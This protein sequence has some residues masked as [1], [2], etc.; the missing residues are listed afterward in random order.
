MEYQQVPYSWM[1]S[2]QPNY[3]NALMNPRKEGEFVTEQ[4]CACPTSQLYAIKFNKVKCKLMNETNQSCELLWF[5]L[6]CILFTILLV[7]FIG[8]AAT[9]DDSAI[10]VGIIVSVAAI[11]VLILYAVFSE[12]THTALEV[13]YKCRSCGHEV[14]VTYEVLPQ[15]F[16]GCAGGDIFNESG[17][18]T[19]TCQEPEPLTL[20]ATAYEDINRTYHDMSSCYHQCFCNSMN[21][22][23]QL[24]NRLR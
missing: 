19:R 18:Y 20:N 15:P 1:Y 10:I 11:I 3:F 16:A 9:H 2:G 14:H 24:I 6:L 23:D 5:G 13:L 7:I 17:R 21:W 12:F 4:R 8:F 22:T